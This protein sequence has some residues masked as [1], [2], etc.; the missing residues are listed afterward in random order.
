MTVTAAIAAG[1]AAAPSAAAAVKRME[2]MLWYNML[3]EMNQSGLDSSE[4]GPGG[5]AYQGMFLWNIAQNDFG[6]YDDTLVSATLRQI[7][8]RSALPPTTEGTTAS[9]PSAPVSDATRATSGKSDGGVEDAILLA[10]ATELARTIWPA[11]QAAASVLRV[12][13][14]AVLAQA[15]LETGWGAAAPGNNL[16]G[17][18]ASGGEVGTAHSTHEM[19][20]GNL[21]PATASFR[22]YG[23]M[24]ESIKD[25]VQVLQ[26]A[27]S[28]AVGQTSV[29][30]FANALQ[31]DGFATDDSYATK[32]IEIAQSPTMAQVLQ[33]VSAPNSDPAAE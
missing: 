29:S 23:S 15:A 1:P 31:A 10:R 2:G 25:Y 26:S 18:K 9:N 13:A 20:N 28:G 12:P 32:I 14:V 30:G 7:G 6:K 3:S 17:I 21:S 27:F 22:D 19:V 8:G 11:I 5:D 24:S 4:L 16:F 33:S